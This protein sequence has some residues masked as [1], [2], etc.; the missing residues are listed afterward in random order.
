MLRG[1]RL[2]R[3]VIVALVLGFIGSFAVGSLASGR[4]TVELSPNVSRSPSSPPGDVLYLPIIA[5]N[6]NP[7]LEDITKRARALVEQSGCPLSFVGASLDTTVTA[8]NR[9]AVVEDIVEK[10]AVVM[11]SDFQCTGIMTLQEGLD[12]GLLTSEN[13][14][15]YQTFVD[16]LVEVGDFVVLVEWIRTS[17][18]ASL[19]TK[20]V[21]DDATAELIYDPMISSWRNPG[22]APGG[23]NPPQ[24]RIQ[25]GQGNTTWTWRP[26]DPDGATIAEMIF[27][28]DTVW[29]NPVMIVTFDEVIS[30]EEDPQVSTFID[31][32]VVSQKTEIIEVEGVQCKRWSFRVHWS[33]PL[34]TVKIKGG[35]SGFDFDVEFGG[36]GS[37]GTDLEV[38]QLCSDGRGIVLEGPN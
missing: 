7:L 23:P 3:V 18:G 20:A 15:E 17:D 12:A 9:D 5:K 32:A 38:Y 31:S 36:I 37:C 24:S 25:T 22:P 14:A 16:G 11:A 29:K 28:K 21:I 2:A 35:T 4:E 19:L 1:E 8:D 26:W 10:T 33:T 34:V 13:V 30:E 27:G 6:Y